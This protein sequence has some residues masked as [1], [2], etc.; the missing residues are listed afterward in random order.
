MM[1]TKEL[2]QDIQRIFYPVLAAV[3]IPVNIMVIVILNQRKCGLSR[4]VTRYM[5]AMAAAD[6]LV[7]VF[8]LTLRHIPILYPNQFRFVLLLPVCNIHSVF[9]YAATDFSVWFTVTFTFDRFVA[10]CSQKLKTTYCTER[11][12]AVVLVTLTAFLCLKDTT[13]Y[14]IHMKTYSMANIPTFCG[15][16]R[17]VSVSHVWGTI[18]VLHYALNPC[19]PF[20][21]I[22]LLNVLTVRNIVVVSRARE[23]LRSH[24]AAESLKDPEMESRRKSIILLFFISGNFIVLWALFTI[25]LI[26]DRIWWLD[27]KINNPSVPARE[28]GFMLQLLSCCT[29]TVIYA[30]T[31]T[32]FRE[33]LKN[34]I[35]YPFSR[36]VEIIQFKEIRKAF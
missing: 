9:L 17:S 4:C 20:V 18:E 13:W 6:L 10:I 32:K 7:I 34:M 35:K 36:I 16:E 22:L 19:V 15:V 2:F 11:T 31:Q 33:L 1:R 28:I 24:V 3:G 21:L 14:F 26:S 23:R 30:V 25:T 27:Y 12:A 8:D 29:N 5:V